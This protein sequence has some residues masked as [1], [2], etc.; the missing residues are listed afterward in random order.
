M[1]IAEP[2]VAREQT[3]H[4]KRSANSGHDFRREH[5]SGGW[6]D[7]FSCRWG[8]EAVPDVITYGVIFSV[9][10]KDK[11]PEPKE[12]PLPFGVAKFLG[13]SNTPKG[14]DPAGK[15][16][17]LEFWKLVW[18]DLQL[19]VWP[20]PKKVAQTFVI[21]Q[22]AFVTVVVLARRTQRRARERYGAREVR[23]DA[24]RRRRRDADD[25]LAGPEFPVQHAF[26]QHEV[27]LYVLRAAR[28]VGF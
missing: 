7:T 20:T 2:V 6:F 8:Q 15:F 25:G 22:T 1:V 4:Q 14:D 3:Q 28:A 16:Y 10:E 11:E 5:S 23:L 17:K 24:R 21:S 19:L 18:E 12:E 13:G 26:P 27:V 9:Y